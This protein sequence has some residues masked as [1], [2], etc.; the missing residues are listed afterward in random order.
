[1]RW[2]FQAAAKL[3]GDDCPGWGSTCRLKRYHDGP[4]DSP[5]KDRLD[6]VKRAAAS[7]PKPNRDPHSTA[8]VPEWAEPEETK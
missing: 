3:S 6:A 4:C 1:V 5:I 2:I 7:A 8:Y